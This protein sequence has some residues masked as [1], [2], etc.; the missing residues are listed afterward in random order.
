MRR[1]T[2][3]ILLLFSVSIFYNII[4]PETQIVGLKMEII[5]DVIAFSVG[6]PIAVYSIIII[7]KIDVPNII[8]YMILTI[9]GMLLLNVFRLALQGE[10]TLVIAARIFTYISVGAA[11]L[12]V[13][14]YKIRKYI[15]LIST[16]RIAVILSIIGFPAVVWDFIFAR[17]AGGFTRFSFIQSI[18]S[19]SVRVP[20]LT[21][22]FYNTNQLSFLLLVGLLAAVWEHH[23]R[24]SILSIVQVILIALGLYLNHSRGAMLSAAIGLVIIELGRRSIKRRDMAMIIACTGVCAGIT[25]LSISIFQASPIVNLTGR[26]EL[27]GA[28]VDAFYRQPVLGYGPRNTGQVIEPYVSGSR[29]SG[30]HPHNAFIRM[31]LT[32]GVFG[33]VSYALLMWTPNI[34]GIQLSDSIDDVIIVGICT[35]ICINQM[36][37]VYT[38]FGLRIQALASAL[39]FGFLIKSLVRGYSKKLKISI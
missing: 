27:W 21:S 30:K 24:Q 23:R 6:I 8:L 18:P 37:E 33:G 13:T 26:M 16:A 9:W 32:S 12:F 22:V 29:L 1:Y 34:H 28:A 11:M 15:V 10:V 19:G 35:S 36:F 14:P 3:A 5:M 39:F 31:F 25:I 38:L 4:H 2:A 17:G 7:D 20:A